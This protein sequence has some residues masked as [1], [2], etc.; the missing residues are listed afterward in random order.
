MAIQTWNAGTIG[1]WFDADKLDH[2]SLL[3]DSISEAGDTVI[4]SSGTAQERPT[5]PSRC[6]GIQTLMAGHRYCRRCD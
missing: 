4:I 5:F 2:T 3:P 6:R 1:E